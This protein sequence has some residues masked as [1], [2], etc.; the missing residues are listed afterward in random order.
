MR[1]A[2]WYNLHNLKNVENTHGGV[3]LLE[4]KVAGSC[5]ELLWKRGWL[6]SGGLQFSHKNKLKSEIF[7]DKK[8]NL[9]ANKEF[10]YF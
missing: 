8:K 3:L 2:I 4:T 10:R 7:N 9:E 1:C 5:C 6:F